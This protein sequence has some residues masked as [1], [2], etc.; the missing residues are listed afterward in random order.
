MY[1]GEEEEVDDEY[2]EE[3]EFL[4]P[5]IKDI[6]QFGVLTLAFDKDIV[7]PSNDTLF[8]EELRA[9]IY[10]EDLQTGRIVRKPSFEVELLQS[11]THDELI[12]FSWEYIGWKND[13]E[14]ELQLV[15]EGDQIELISMEDPAD[16]VNITFWN[17]G[18]FISKEGLYV[19]RQTELNEE[20]PLQV[21]DDDFTS[22]VTIMGK[23]FSGA[24]FGGGV[25]AILMSLCMQYGLF[26]LWNLLHSVQLIIHLP[27]LSVIFPKHAAI[28][29]D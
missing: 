9:L 8:E 6:D 16:F 27:M 14:M 18:L 12:N 20:I 17:Q 26:W 1:E 21:Y 15:Y 7:R 4:Q 25:T 23:V 29:Y 10:T 5:Y 2:S 11:E 13:K 24:I 22:T 3:K 28:F 19:R